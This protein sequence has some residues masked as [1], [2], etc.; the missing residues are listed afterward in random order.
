MEEASRAKTAFITSEGLFEFRNAFR[1]YERPQHLPACHEQH[2]QPSPQHCLLMVPGRSCLVFGKSTQELARNLHTVLRRRLID[3]GMAVNTKKCKIGY[4]RRFLPNLSDSATRPLKRP[5]GGNQG[6]KW[7]T[8]GN[9]GNDETST[10]LHA[11]TERGS[12]VWGILM[13]KILRVINMP[14]DDV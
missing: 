6:W 10:N 8:R 7:E 3:S 13:R 2:A 4:Y 12:N 9:Q 1:P 14:V 11:G 5:A